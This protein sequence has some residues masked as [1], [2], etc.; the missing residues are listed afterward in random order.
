[1]Y[2]YL[3]LGKFEIII[4]DEQKLAEKLQGKLLL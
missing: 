4:A 2:T 1:M 3:L